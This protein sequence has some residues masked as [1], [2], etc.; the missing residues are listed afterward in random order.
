MLAQVILTPTESKRLISKAIAGMQ[1]VRRAAKEGMV[2]LQPS[3]STY[4]II[5]E[6][7][8]NKLDMHSS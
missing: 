3:S 8:G 2:V 7:T 4:F 6:L 1:L 5:E